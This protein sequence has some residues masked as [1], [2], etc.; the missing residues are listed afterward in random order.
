M[1]VTKVCS[2]P[3]LVNNFWNVLNKGINYRS[4]TIPIHELGIT[5]HNSLEIVQVQEAMAMKR[6]KARQI[7]SALL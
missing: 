2:S 4:N 3:H 1:V 5:K 7:S 6:M